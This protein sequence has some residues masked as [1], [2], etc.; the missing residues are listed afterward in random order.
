[1]QL[2]LLNSSTMSA[3]ES[4]TELRK[5][6]KLLRQL[7]QLAAKRA[8]GATLNKDEE[9]KLNRRGDV[10]AYL[11]TLGVDV[12]ELPPVSVPEPMDCTSTT[13][14]VPTQPAESVPVVV[15]VT[16]QPVATAVT[17]KP[18]AVAKPKP[19]PKQTPKQIVAAPRTLPAQ[20]AAPQVF[21]PSG[22][23]PAASV[24][25]V[26][27]IRWPQGTELELIKAEVL[28]IEK[29]ADVQHNSSFKYTLRV[30]D[31]PVKVG[32]SV[33]NRVTRLLNM[34][35]RHISHVAT[36]VFA[37][38]QRKHQEVVEVAPEVESSD[39]SDSED[40]KQ[41]KKAK[42]TVVAKAPVKESVKVPV[43]SAKPVVVPSQPIA[44]PQPAKKEVAPTPKPVERKAVPQVEKAVVAA[45]APTVVQ[46]STPQVQPMQTPAV[47]VQTPV[48]P[49]VQSSAQPIVQPI[50]QAPIVP[51]VA[52]PMPSITP[53]A[54]RPAPVHSKVLAPMVGGS[55]LAFRLLCRRYGV[56]LAYTPM[57]MS[58]QFV[59]DS[60]Y[61]AKEFQ[62]VILTLFI[63]LIRASCY[64]VVFTSC[65]Q[66]L[67][68]YYYYYFF[69]Y[70][71]FFLS[72]VVRRSTS[73]GTLCCQQPA[74]LH[75]RRTSGGE[76]MRRRRLEFGLPAA[77][78]SLG[79]LWQLSI[80]R[81]RSRISAQH[82]TQY[83]LKT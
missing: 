23:Q 82:G 55:E 71:F 51:V 11:K 78:C 63:S 58:D 6:T 10:V 32:T 5:A 60:E 41:P 64:F 49:P 40:E 65:L 66:K 70:I 18:A 20:P 8:G 16:P 34:K 67:F 68:I 13:V 17:P 75:G 35:W 80:G 81:F 21:D 47:V 12:P 24:G 9:T 52:R 62:T 15:A 76:Q 36:H 73:G 22:P 44:V 27:R 48:Q 31:V 46:P 83:H 30:L 37:T 2:P 4:N 3:A 50:V 74:H 53:K 7:D 45:V 28:S 54:K 59:N 25:D 79:T 56:D 1:M 57:M 69:F 26:L 19:T 42:V 39:S 43:V 61:R 77:H 33:P 38:P 14:E 29:C 72:S